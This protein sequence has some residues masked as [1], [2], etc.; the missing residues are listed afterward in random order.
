MKIK[1][2]TTQL[3]IGCICLIQALVH[4]D[5]A[6]RSMNKERQEE[7]DAKKAAKAAETAKAEKA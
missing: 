7:L 1:K 2:S 4:L 6:E 5:S 3:I